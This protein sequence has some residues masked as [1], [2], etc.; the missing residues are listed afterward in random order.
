MPSRAVRDETMPEDPL[1]ESAP[2][3]E[4]APET[5]T[6]QLPLDA[7]HQRTAVQTILSDFEAAK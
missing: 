2:M 1:G 4:Q 7:A 6:L 5:P 3:E